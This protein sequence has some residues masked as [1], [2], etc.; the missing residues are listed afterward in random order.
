MC[1]MKVCTGLG[2]G[3][4]V[5]DKHVGMP[6]I[7]LCMECM[8]VAENFFVCISLNVNLFAHLYTHSTYNATHKQ[9]IDKVKL[10][11]HCVLDEN[12]WYVRNLFVYEVDG[13]LCV[14]QIGTSFP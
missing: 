8:C 7:R 10:D 4:Y 1:P 9:T 5:D 11:N 14:V 2:I 6:G 3:K 12:T 13:R